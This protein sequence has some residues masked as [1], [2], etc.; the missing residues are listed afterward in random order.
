MQ[1]VYTLPAASVG[2][3]VVSLCRDSQGRVYMAFREETATRW[4]LNLAY[5]DDTVTWTIINVAEKIKG[6]G[7][8]SFSFT[9]DSWDQ[10]HF[11][12]TSFGVVN[13]IQDNLAYRMYNRTSGLSVITLLTDTAFIHEQQHIAV[14]GSNNL[15][16]IFRDNR[17]G[18]ADTIYYW[19][20][21]DNVWQAEQI[22][23]QNL[24]WNQQPQ[25]IFIGENNVRHVVWVGEGYDVNPQGGI[26]YIFSQGGHWAASTRI[27]I[28]DDAI[29]YDVG[30]AVT[31]SNN[32][33]HFT[34]GK[35]AAPPYYIRYRRY[36]FG[37]GLDPQQDVLTDNPHE[38]SHIAID[39][40]NI[41]IASV[42]NVP[43]RLRLLRRPD[44]GS[45]AWGPSTIITG[46][47]AWPELRNF[48]PSL[49]WPQVNQ[50][51]N[52]VPVIGWSAAIYSD[53]GPGLSQLYYGFS[54]PLI[55]PTP[56]PGPSVPSVSTLPAS[57][58]T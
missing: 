18:L 49:F 42:L 3:G 56:P 45:T 43:Y 50:L 20:R 47:I 25:G 2:I 55:W 1:L 32:S 58:V 17:T 52:N 51:Q 6:A 10:L 23:A 19:Q 12:F 34:W 38:G 31:K 16:F 14:D 8:F 33:V 53:V 40:D 4:L 30:L 21:I 57:V 29:G 9:I 26:Q 46:A 15:H 41:Y 36:V 39:S 5:S 28:T 27:P 22:V 13:P 35:G 7:G 37:A 44:D 54:Y 11:L 24:G 48:L